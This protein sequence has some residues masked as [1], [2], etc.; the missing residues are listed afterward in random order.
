MLQ[1]AI[2]L[3]TLMSALDTTIWATLLPQM[4]S[5]LGQENLYPIMSSAYFAA[6]LLTIPIIGKVT[7]HFGCKIPGFISLFFFCL[8]S[9]L[10]ALSPSMSFLVFA[11]FVEGCG[12]GALMTIASISV[13]KAFEKDS[14]RSF[15]QAVMSV[16]WAISGIFGPTASAILASSFSWRFAF[17]IIVPIGA[18]AAYFWAT[19]SE[20]HEKQATRFDK[21]SLVLFLLAALFCFLFP[22]NLFLESSKALLFFTFIGALLFVSL[23][24][25]RSFHSPSP[26]V[27]IRLLANPSVALLVI[28]G[29]VTGIA[30]TVIY[31]LLSL[32]AQ[33]GLLLSVMQASNCIM[34]LTLGWTIG[35]FL[36]SFIVMRKSLHAALLFGIGALAFGMGGCALW[37]RGFFSLLAYSTFMGLGLGAVINSSIVS[38][39]RACAPHLLGRATSF[40]GLMRHFGTS[41]GAQAAGFLQL[42]FFRSALLGGKEFLTV[43]HLAFFSCLPGKFLSKGM[44]GD[45]SPSELSFLSS[46]L[47][48]S[49]EKVFALPTALLCLAFLVFLF[50]FPKKRSQELV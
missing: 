23:L 38:I 8:G 17:L 32:F 2:V 44:R 9:I 27:P 16:V 3:F 45:L 37:A 47:A 33:G 11:R 22:I 43:E 42:Y 24:L 48:D 21:M 35:S 29:F 25:Y 50:V 6:F 20:K 49:I 7:D 1:V 19:F 4:I 13:A 36:C 34:M 12:A 15:M 31:T 39:Q 28:L 5:S 40:L 30:M 14:R 46:S 41:I 10:S 18:I 26:I